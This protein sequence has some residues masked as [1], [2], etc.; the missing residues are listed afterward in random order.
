MAIT[1]GIASIPSR[2][3]ELEFV[4]DSLV[5]QVDQIFLALNYE[6]EERPK[7]LDNYPNVYWWVDSI[8]KGDAEKFA[9]AQHVEGYYIG[10]DDDLRCGNS[11]I[12]KRLIDGVDKY[13]GLVSF[14]GKKYLPPVTDYRKWA[15]NYRCLGRVSEDVKVNFIGSGCCAFHTDRLKVSL[16]DFKTKNMADVYLSKL[17]TEQGVPMVV[18]AHEPRDLHYTNPQGGTI[19]SETKDYTEHIKIMRTFIK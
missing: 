15:G 13:N 9:M 10:W 18:L 1:L 4:L 6:E 2:K 8:N 11:G 3:N 17:A 14:H 12:I 19:W 16:Q 5:G 7:Y